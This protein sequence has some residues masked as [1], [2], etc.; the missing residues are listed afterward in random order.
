MQLPDILAQ[1]DHWVAV[2]KPSGMVVHRSRGANDRYNLVSVMRAHLGPEIY[3]VNRLDRKTSGVLVMAIG[4]DAARELSTAFAERTVE[5]EYE[6]VVRGWPPL[7]PQQSHVIERELSGRPAH[8]TVWVLGR[9]EL[10]V[11]LGRYPKTRLARVRLRPHTGLTHQLRRHMQG[12]GYPVINDK[13]HGDN[14]LNHRFFETYGV[15]R[16]LLHSRRL[17]F[18]FD[19]QRITV[20]ADWNG[21]SLGLL[22]FLGLH[23]VDPTKEQGSSKRTGAYVRKDV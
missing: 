23:N 21:R 20:E 4:K 13:Q 9:S 1:T 17:T 18:P 6:A 11:Q 12:W 14:Q 15:K 2:D 3:P 10:D 8:S 16:L 22:Q 5:K 7:E 19:G